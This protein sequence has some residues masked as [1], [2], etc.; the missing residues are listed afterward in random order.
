VTDAVVLDASAVLA[1]IRGEP[2]AGEVERLDG[3]PYLSAVNAMEVMIV[4]GRAGLTAS[5]ARAVL[6]A[7]HLQVIPFVPGLAERAAEVHA[8]ARRGGLSLADAICL[9]T[10]AALGAVVYTA[11]KAWRR[12]DLGIQI[13]LIR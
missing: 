4:L 1:L 6:D 5:R 8:K 13:R 3:A 10:A 9:A 12:V 7:L 2:G 11:D